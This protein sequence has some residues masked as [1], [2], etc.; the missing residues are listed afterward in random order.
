MAETTIEINDAEAFAGRI[1]RQTC[2][3]RCCADFHDSHDNVLCGP[4]MRATRR[5]ALLRHARTDQISMPLGSSLR[6]K[7]ALPLLFPGPFDFTAVTSSHTRS[8]LRKT[9]LAHI[10]TLFFPHPSL[11]AHSAH[12]LL[13]FVI[14]A[15]FTPRSLTLPQKAQA[16]FL[17]F[18]RSGHRRSCEDSSPAKVLLS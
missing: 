7:R 16:A 13:T 10:C 11:N 17:Y 9:L 14:V 1:P 18:D 12:T 4:D 3:K 15:V 8:L 5:Q 6:V 2:P